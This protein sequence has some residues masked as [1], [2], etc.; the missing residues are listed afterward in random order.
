MSLNTLIF[1]NRIFRSLSRDA[2]LLTPR[3]LIRASRDLMTR[4]VKWTGFDRAIRVL[5]S[6]KVLN[7][8]IRMQAGSEHLM[9]SAMLLTLPY[10]DMFGTY[11]S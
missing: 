1:T 9:L 5:V 7:T 3:D 11:Y 6:C 4:I 8:A 10:K 2:H